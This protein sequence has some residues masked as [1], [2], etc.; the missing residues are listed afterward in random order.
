MFVFEHRKRDRRKETIMKR[1]LSLSA[2]EASH[3]DMDYARLYS[4]I[5]SEIALG[6][7]SPVKASGLNGK[8]PAL[9][10]SYWKF[11]QEKEYGEYKE[12]LAYQLSPLL[13]PDF[14]LKNPERYQKDRDK[15]LLLSE[16]LNQCSDQLKIPMTINERSF[17]IFHREKFLDREGGAELL[18]R[19]SVPEELLNFYATSEPMSYYSHS[20][21]APQVILIIENKDTFYSMRKYL[22]EGGR[23]V[24]GLMV[25]TLIYGGGKGILRSFEDYIDAAEPYFAHR[26]NKLYYFGDLDYEGMLIYELLSRKYGD[27][28]QIELFVGA[29]ERMV[30]KAEQIGFDS[31]PMRREGQNTHAGEYFLSWFS[32]EVR[33]KMQRILESDRYI[34]QEILHVGEYPL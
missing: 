29:Y 19:L 21:Q 28:K 18:S 32:D 27:R 5:C 23:E 14:Y 11:E 20:K 6:R 3:P 34:P 9:F 4:Y 24:M 1:K 10:N 30:Q 17:A 13:K 31:L 8:K 12:E 15:I 33:G 22:T 25:G 26:E 2:L 7:L 16:Y